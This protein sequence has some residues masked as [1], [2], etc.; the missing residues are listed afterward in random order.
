MRRLHY[1]FTIINGSRCRS[2]GG[3]EHIRIK[4]SKV[5]CEFKA[6]SFCRGATFLSIAHSK[7][8]FCAAAMG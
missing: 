4:L 5:F 6:Y 8:L 1:L 2:E 3:A 7:A